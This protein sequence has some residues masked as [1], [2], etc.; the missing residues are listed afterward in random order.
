MPEIPGAADRPWYRDGLPFTCTQC[1]HCC[2]IEGYVWVSEEE[3]EILAKHLGLEVHEFGGRYLRRVG[4][5]FSLKEKPN[6]E[7]I[8][9]DQGCSVYAARP[10]QCRTFPFWPENIRDPKSW[11]RVVS[12]C[13]GSGR[14]RKYSY[15]EIERLRRGIG[16]TG[17]PPTGKGARGKTPG[18]RS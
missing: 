15:E 14:G 9:W 6:H 17:L 5:R 16:E 12:E 7:C 4:N 18:G 1:G 8:F 2:N 3:I 10:V 11:D 13:P